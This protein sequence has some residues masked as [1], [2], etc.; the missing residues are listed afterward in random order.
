MTLARFRLDGILPAPRG[1]PQVEV[2]FD[3]DANGIL[4]VRAK[5]LGT[6]REQSVKVTASTNLTQSDIERMV[7]DAEQY[8]QQDAEVRAAAEERN[9][10]DQ[11]AYQT[12]K[13]L[14]EAGDRI[15]ETDR[16]SVQGALDELLKALKGSDIARVRSARQGLEQAW[17]PVAS[18]LYSRAGAGVGPG[19]GG[20]SGDDLSGRPEDDDVVDAE[21]RSSDE[22]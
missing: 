6:G 16:R 1:M 11:L 18:S 10:A 17:Q 9:T 3:I 2:T 21:F 15:S 5:D 7:K 14:R 22:G 4:S 20:A 8:A 12:E 13:T 19:E